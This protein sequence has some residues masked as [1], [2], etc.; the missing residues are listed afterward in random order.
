VEFFGDE[1][2]TVVIGDVEVGAESGEEAMKG[3]GPGE[4]AD[5]EAMVVAGT[6]DEGAGEAV[7]RWP[8]E[9]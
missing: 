8:G 6:G 4:G 1:E 5:S 9:G 7:E 2:I 3:A